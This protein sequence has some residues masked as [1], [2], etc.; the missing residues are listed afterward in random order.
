M[1]QR[2]NQ[3]SISNDNGKTFGERTILSE[4]IT[5]HISFQYQNMSQ[6][7]AANVTQEANLEQTKLDRLHNLS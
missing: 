3:Y 7:W 2:M 5:I 1:Q 4:K 6:A